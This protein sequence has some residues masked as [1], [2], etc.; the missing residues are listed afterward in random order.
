MRVRLNRI[1]ITQDRNIIVY[2]VPQRATME[3]AETCNPS[4]TPTPPDGR[5]SY[6]LHRRGV[7][8][9]AGHDGYHASVYTYMRTRIMR[10][11]RR[12][13][14]GGVCALG[15]QRSTAREKGSRA[16]FGGVDF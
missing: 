7:R 4:P 5:S 8:A 15:C 12:Q 9:R 3:A 2:A 6:N 10:R 1:Y 13:R 14:R 11:R 16:R